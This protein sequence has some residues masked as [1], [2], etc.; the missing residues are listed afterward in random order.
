[1]RP[2]RAKAA[3]TAR[4]TKPEAPVTRMPV[5]FFIHQCSGANPVGIRSN[6]E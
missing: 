2:D 4:P 5:M 1:V 6:G 3:T